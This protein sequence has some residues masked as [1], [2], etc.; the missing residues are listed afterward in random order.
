MAIVGAETGKT[1]GQLKKENRIRDLE[2]QQQIDTFVQGALDQPTPVPDFSVVA[3]LNPS[4]EAFISGGENFLSDPLAVQRREI[5]GELQGP[6]AAARVLNPDVTEQ[7][8]QNYIRTPAQRDF[9]D[10]LSQA[11]SYAAGLGAHQSGGFANIIGDSTAQ[12]NDTLLG[13]RSQLAQQNM[14]ATLGSEEARLGRL[15]GQQ[16]QLMR[17]QVGGLGALQTTGQFERGIEQEGLNEKFNRF[18]AEQPF[19]NPIVNQFLGLALTDAQGVQPLLSS[20]DSGGGLAGL[21]S[22][23]PGPV[24]DVASIAQIFG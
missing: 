16:S 13:V 21:L 20:S 12:F 7:Y 24:G 8:F 9:N 1:K 18:L 23:V 2:L 15:Q 14:M 19:T 11:S 3:G 22:A 10:S 6:S 17:E 5:A 4:L